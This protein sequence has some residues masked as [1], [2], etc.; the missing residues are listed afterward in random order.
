VEKINTKEFVSNSHTKQT[1][2]FGYIVLKLF[3]VILN[4]LVPE[5]IKKKNNPT[6]WKSWCYD[7]KQ[8]KKHKQK[9]K[10]L[11]IASLLFRSV[12]SNAPLNLLPEKLYSI[13][14][15]NGIKYVT[16]FMY[17]YLLLRRHFGIDKIANSLN[18]DLVTPA[19]DLILFNFK[20]KL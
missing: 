9:F 8:Q 13:I 3:H 7:V 15:A 6:S 10:W 2:I 18:G 4:E 14:Q 20:E 11:E 5:Y 16:A 1:R 12:K 19:Q 17:L